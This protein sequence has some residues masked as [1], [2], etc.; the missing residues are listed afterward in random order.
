M[1]NNGSAN[2]DG[3]HWDLM[4]R[5][6]TERLQQRFDKNQKSGNK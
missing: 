3:D 5:L 2:E 1:G 4:K 6:K